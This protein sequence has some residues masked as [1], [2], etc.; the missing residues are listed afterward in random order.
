MRLISTTTPAKTGYALVI[1]LVFL[2]VTIILLTGA[3]RVSS[4]SVQLTARNVQYTR[5]LY[6]AEAATEKVVGRITYDF[7]GADPVNVY[8]H[9]AEYRLLIPASAEK[10][11]WSNYTFGDDVGTRGCNSVSNTA[12]WKYAALE[13]QYIGL[14]GLAAKYRVTSHARETNAPFDMTASVQQ[15]I[16]IATIPL[17]QFA[18]FYGMDMEIS[19]GQQFN[20]TG[21]VHSNGKLYVEPDSTLTFFSDVTAVGDILFQR[22]PGDSR[23]APVGSV[24]YQADRDGMVT[25]LNLPIGTNNTSEAVRALLDPPP[26]GEDSTSL[27]GQQRYYNKSDLILR[28]TDNIQINYSYATNYTYTSNKVGSVWKCTSTN[29]TIVTNSTSITNVL[30]SGTSGLYNN[31]GLD[32]PTNYLT[33]FVSLQS[34]FYDAREG[35][36]VRPV[37]LDIGR[38]ATNSALTTYLGRSVRTLYVDDD[39]SVS[40]NTNTD[41]AAV[42]LTNGTSLPSGGLTVVTPFPLYIQGH[43][44]APVV[45]DRGTTNTSGTLPAAV[46]ADAIT[47]LSPTWKDSLSTAALTSRIATNCTVNAAFLSGT[48]PTTNYNTYSG[49][50]ENFPRFLEG[51]NPSS[52][53]KTFTYNGSMV[54]MF[55]SRYAYHPWGQANIYD[56][57]ARNW[58]FDQ[59]FTD[60]NKLPPSTPSVSTLIRAQWAIVPPRRPGN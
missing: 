25:S 24:S 2:S 26:T 50:A 29:T 12:T 19:C 38:L 58:A 41:L 7:K 45:A 40:L 23:T 49:G 47:I 18:I 28:V 42:R 52:G 59:N 6:A 27:M 1:V 22:A 35:K 54:V 21:R 14:Y 44:N 55:A 31:F 53:K 4:T 46:I 51:W 11:L 36:T 16:Q 9:L 56:P 5:T 57:P 60:L 10:Q 48:V 8:N 43:Y 13:S 32:I 33:S 20:V 39:R 15:D 3:L 30:I 34:Q 17:F 37:N